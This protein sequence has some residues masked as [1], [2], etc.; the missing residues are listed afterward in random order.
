MKKM[1]V[2]VL[3][4]ADEWEESAAILRNAGLE[5][6]AAPALEIRKLTPHKALLERLSG[7]DIVIFASARAVRTFFSEGENK[8]GFPSVARVISIGERTHAE[9]ARHGVDSLKPA[10]YSS[11]GIVEL[12]RTMRTE[13][14][15]VVV[16]RSREGSSTLMEGLRSMGFDVTEIPLYSVAYPRNDDALRTLVRDIA[17]GGIYALPFTSAMMVR[18]FF[19]CAEMNCIMPQFLQ[20][21][22]D[23]SLWSIGPETSAVLREAGAVFT[24]AAVADYASIA[25]TIASVDR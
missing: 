7:A 25:A 2:G 13:G 24:E 21:L 22:A 18:N 20:K 19:R 12:V 10:A 8:T 11:A 14:V 1:K 9:L 16:M 23:C 5:P 6:V 4:P 15:S 17:R 3:R